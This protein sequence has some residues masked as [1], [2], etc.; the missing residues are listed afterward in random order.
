[1]LPGVCIYQGQIIG[2]D[3][4]GCRQVEMAE[5]HAAHNTPLASCMTKHAW[6][7][8]NP[9]T[10]RTAVLVYRT[11]AVES[12]LVLYNKGQHVSTDMLGCKA[13]VLYLRVVPHEYP[14]FALCMDAWMV[15]G[16]W[17]WRPR[18]R[19]RFFFLQGKTPPIYDLPV[20]IVAPV[21]SSG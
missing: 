6:P 19:R 18:R 5:E 1:M 9:Y 17:E 11:A 16:F 20:S 14:V 2:T 15:E 12:R 4:S 8:F 10:R 3:S 21:V 13:N 7:C